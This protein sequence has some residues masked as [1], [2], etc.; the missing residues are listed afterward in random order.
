MRKF[1]LHGGKIQCI[2]YADKYETD[3]KGKGE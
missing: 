2:I 3:D 1:L